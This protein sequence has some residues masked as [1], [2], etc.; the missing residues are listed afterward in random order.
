MARSVKCGHVAAIGG[1]RVRRRGTSVPKIGDKV[2]LT[3]RYVAALRP[4]D[5]RS[6]EVMDAVQRGLALRVWPSGKLI[7]RARACSPG[8]IRML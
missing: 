7:T 2:R 1:A 4:E 5:G 8:V 6:L 3:D